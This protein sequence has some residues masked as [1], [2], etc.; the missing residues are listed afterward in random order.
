MINR[1]NR[2]RWAVLVAA[3]LFLFWLL[4]SGGDGAA[5]AAVAAVVGG[6]VSAWL[7]P[8]TLHRPRPLAVGRFLALFVRQSLVGGADVA[9]RALHPRMPL[10]PS[11]AEY[12]V[13]LRTPAGQAL[14]MITV[15]L[16]PGTLCADVRN[17]VMRVHS[18]TPDRDAGLPGVERAVAAIFGEE[19][20]QVPE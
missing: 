3:C 12:P 2:I 8:G 10:E 15:S 9:W 14:F 5:Y 13:S 20:A 1:A 16:T 19:S 7:A 6:L 4:L 17:G 11:W 18:L